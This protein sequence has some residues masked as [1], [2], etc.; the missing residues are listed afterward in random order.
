MIK[1]C[2]RY[3]NWL[4]PAAAIVLALLIAIPVYANPGLK[5]AGAI[6]VA[7]VSPQATLTH[8]MTVSL[9]SGDPA[10]DITVQVGGIGQSLD[11]A[12]EFLEAFEDTSQY[13]ARQF[14]TVD[15]AS[16]H[17]E[18]GASQDITATIHILQD[19]GAGGRYALINIKAG[20]AGAGQVATVAAVN[21]PIALTVKDTQLTHQGKI[22]ALTTSEA[23][24]GQPVAIFTTFQNTGNHHFKVKG[25][26]TI[27][28]SQGEVLDTILMPLT[29]SSVIP[30][31]SLRL[32]AAFIPK[33]ALAA[34]VYSVKSKV[35]LDD[36]TIL[37]EKEGSFELGQ[38]YTPP[39]PTTPQ[40]TQPTPAVTTPIPPA[41]TPPA[42]TPLTPSPPAP[43]A[44]NW[45]MVGGIAGA[46]I[47][48][49]FLI[50]ILARRRRD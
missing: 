29:A 16:F 40:T 17:L 11:G 12:Y 18:P 15:K 13:S 26:V 2:H 41:T 50:V 24:S 23:V 14:I 8:K 48:V 44:I 7:D 37:D 1:S 49:V 6:L 30:T 33:G 45:P 19:V 36:S 38:T 46:V 47:I 4:L 10:T 21:V 25:E 32:R 20:P 42:T 9:G 39:P 22:T 5:V 28:N 34:G 31:M 35:M 3:I 27:S 43:A